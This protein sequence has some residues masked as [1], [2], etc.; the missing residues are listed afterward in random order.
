MWL[1]IIVFILIELL[2][3]QKKVL[4]LPYQSITK[5]LLTHLFNPYDN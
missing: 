1:K 5:Y 2:Q 4:S 3:N